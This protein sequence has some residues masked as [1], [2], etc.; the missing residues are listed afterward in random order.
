MIDVPTEVSRFQS[1]PTPRQSFIIFIRHQNKCGFCT[2]IFCCGE[3]RE[4][5][6][7]KIHQEEMSARKR[8][9]HIRSLCYLCNAQKLPFGPEFD[10]LTDEVLQH[11]IAMHLPLKCNKCSRCYDTAAD[12]GD[13]DKCCPPLA[14][15]ESD[16]G[17]DLDSDGFK[18]P[19]GGLA[20][21]M[22]A[23]PLYSKPDSELE[24]EGRDNLT[25]LTKINLV[26][27]QKSSKSEGAAVEKHRSTST[28]MQTKQKL[29]TTK[30]FTDSY[31]HSSIQISSINYASTSSES[32]DANSPPA[33]SQNVQSKSSSAF[34]LPTPSRSRPKSKVQTPLRQVMSKSIQKAIKEHGKYQDSPL[35]Q[36]KMSFNST[37]SSGE[38]AISL[39][40]SGV[41]L[42]LSLSP[43]VRRFEAQGKKVQSMG[44]ASFAQ[45]CS[46][47]N[48]NHPDQSDLIDQ[49]V[50]DL[51]DFR[52]HIEFEQIEVIIRRSEIKSDSAMTNYRTC[53]NESARSG[54]MPI[55]LDLCRTPK[56]AGHN[57][58]KKT[59]S[60]EPPNTIEKTPAFIMPTASDGNYS[61]DEADDVFYTPMKFSPAR[62]P[63]AKASRADD[64][65]PIGSD[66]VESPPEKDAS[67]SRS[68]IWDLVSSVMGAFKSDDSG[69]SGSENSW[70]FSFKR[71]DFVKKA[72]E[73]F[74]SKCADDPDDNDQPSKRRRISSTSDNRVASPAHKRMKIQSRRPIG[75]MENQTQD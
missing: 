73:Y 30:S 56:I 48:E 69:Q 64:P 13:V 1:Y 37:N 31:S 70:N 41:L 51:I 63:Y 29:S 15:L 74:T 71:P 62:T 59:I 45:Q 38:Q 40:N 26:W 17:S 33:D 4:K 65:I 42:D 9:E 3:C 61:E 7:N 10:F 49:S 68:N 34:K 54:T 28:P 53:V 35:Q 14:L 6:E 60:F 67:K 19:P 24:S 22:V 47:Q 25:P 5:H 21:V 72:T 36:R 75:R 50:P 32:S 8:E 46:L 11:V 2:K 16:L 55:S 20:M 43:A 39:M 18:T 23:S 44:V 52:S 12:F 27:R 57:F 58:L 66:A